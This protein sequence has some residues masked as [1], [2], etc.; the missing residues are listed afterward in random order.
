MSEATKYAVISAGGR[1]LTVQTGQRV[2]LDCCEGDAGSSVKLGNVLMLGSIGSEAKV[3]TP[4]VDGATITVKILGDSKGEKLVA[5]KR[6]RRKGFK[7][8]IGHRQHFTEV[9]VEAING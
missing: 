9:L 5:F 4:V 8:K 1:Q 3:G 2:L 6:K 7:K